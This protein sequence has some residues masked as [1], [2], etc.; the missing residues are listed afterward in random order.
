MCVFLSWRV[1]VWLTCS[2]L[3]LSVGECMYGGYVLVSICLLIFSQIL[4]DY[5][6]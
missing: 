6:Y 1:Y 5:G 4:N 2:C 3:I